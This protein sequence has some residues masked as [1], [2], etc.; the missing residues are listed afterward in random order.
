VKKIGFNFQ[1]IPVLQT[2]KRFKH[3][4]VIPVRKTLPTSW[5]SNMY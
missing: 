2:K 5:T 1:L 4:L 3:D